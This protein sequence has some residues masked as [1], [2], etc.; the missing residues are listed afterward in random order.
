MMRVRLLPLPPFLL[1][2]SLGLGCAPSHAQQA[3][4]L[5]QKMG[6]AEFNQ[7]GLDKLDP[8]ELQHLQ[9]WLADHAAE[10]AALVPASA[11]A[12]A[13]VA[14]DRNPARGGNGPG[15]AADSADRSAGRIVVSPVAGHF[16]G[17]RPG[18]VLTLQ[19]GQKWRVSDNSSLTTPRPVDNPEA[20]VKP[21]AFG[22][23]LFKVKGYNT[24]AR[25]EPAN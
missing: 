17:W 8:A 6:P 4:V 20:T 1:A 21:G 18:S 19:N 3:I 25:V 5:Q 16:E 7:A 10:L 12:S 22:G 15:R 14:A 11:A 23:W 9:Q 13:S 2:L 24:S